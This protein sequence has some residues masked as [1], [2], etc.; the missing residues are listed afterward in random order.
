MAPSPPPLLLIVLLTILTTLCLSAAGL[1][2][3]R[4]DS[5]RSTWPLCV[6]F[7]VLAVAASGRV[8]G[9]FG[10]F[11]AVPLL[12]AFFLPLVLTLAPLLYWTGRGLLFRDH[13]WRRTDPIHL[14]PCVIALGFFIVLYGD[15]SGVGA[16]LLR[17]VGSVF[18]VEVGIEDVIRA[19]YWLFFLQWTLYGAAIVVSQSRGHA[20]RRAFF[21]DVNQAAERRMRYILLFVLVPWLSL[22]LQFTLSALGFPGLLEPGASL[23]R[24]ACIGAFAIYALDQPWI[25]EAT[26]STP[27]RDPVPRYQRSGLDSADLDRI[28][29]KLTRTMEQDRLY[30]E[31]TLTLRDLSDAT[32][33]REN[34]LSETLNVRLGVSFFDFVNDWRIKEAEVLLRTTDRTVLAILLDVGFNARSTFNA[35]F[36]KRIGMTPSAYRRQATDRSPAV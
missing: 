17:N 11:S 16:A 8:I 5:D 29:A 18:G 1:L 23:F 33:I 14:L 3:R 15:Q 24:M 20:R 25:F 19:V 4:R 27:A 35:A 31:S 22:L 9:A 6:A 2:A 21:S 13:S 7:A 26:E 36:R 10:V 28:A 30:R 32:Q 12:R 34:H